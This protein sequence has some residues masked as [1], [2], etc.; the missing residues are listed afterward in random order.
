MRKNRKININDI[1]HQPAVLRLDDYVKANEGGFARINYSGGHL[2]NQ[3]KLCQ[4]F[5]QLIEAIRRDKRHRI[6][7]FA[8][9]MHKRSIFS[10][11]ITILH[12]VLPYCVF[13]LREY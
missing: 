13:S 6:R 9:R 12:I 10:F 2:K 8:L 11:H 5:E 7:G 1:R 4:S 3:A